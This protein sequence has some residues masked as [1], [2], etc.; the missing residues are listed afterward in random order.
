M[1]AS[2]RLTLAGTDVGVFV[3]AFTLD[4]K[5]IQ[6]FFGYLNPPD[7]PMDTHTATGAMMTMVSNRLSYIFDFRGPSISG[8][9]PHARRRSSPSTWRARAS[10][11]RRMRDGARPPRWRVNVMVTR[12]PVA[13]HRRVEG[14]LSSP[15]T[16][17]ASRSAPP[18][19]ATAAPRAPGSSS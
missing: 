15:P 3:G 14:R 2:C 10:P 12:A 13:Q 8:S 9:T 11:Q 19:T 18:P 16:A 1:P 6:A 5:A 7:L 17:A 4:Y